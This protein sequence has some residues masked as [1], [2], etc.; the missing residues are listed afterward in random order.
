MKTGCKTIIINL[1]D[2]IRTSDLKRSSR[3]TATAA[4][5]SSVR[6]EDR[7]SKRPTPVSVE[8]YQKHR[9]I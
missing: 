2:N 1:K 9:L 6:S 3:D 4:S 7:Q 8:S 5:H